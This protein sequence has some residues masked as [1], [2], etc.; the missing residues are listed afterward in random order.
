MLA[1]T[2]AVTQPLQGRPGQ[3]RVQGSTGLREG[4]IASTVTSDAVM[5]MQLLW[6]RGRAGQLENSVY[7]CNQLGLAGASCQWLQHP[8]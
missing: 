8:R 5:R 6:V 1:S 4:L 2:L 7:N 3:V